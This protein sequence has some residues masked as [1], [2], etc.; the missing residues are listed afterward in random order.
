[1]PSFLMEK[2]KTQNTNS[3]VK[4]RPVLYHVSHS[5]FIGQ[6]FLKRCCFWDYTVTILKC[7]L[8]VMESIK[9]NTMYVIGIYNR[10]PAAKF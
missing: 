4:K 2:Y 7:Y 1:M 5:I 9:G 8:Y 6:N 3:T 10:S